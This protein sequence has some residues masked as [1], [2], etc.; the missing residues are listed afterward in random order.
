MEVLD[1]HYTPPPPPSSSS[2]NDLREGDVHKA[3]SSCL[4]TL[5]NLMQLISR[6]QQETEGRGFLTDDE[7][8][9]NIPKAVNKDKCSMDANLLLN[10]K[11]AISLL[12]TSRSSSSIRSGHHVARV[13]RGPSVNLP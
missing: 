10:F 3:A 4:E 11:N 8:H 2:F 1:S 7:V 5:Q 6:Q 12:N 13:K 9:I